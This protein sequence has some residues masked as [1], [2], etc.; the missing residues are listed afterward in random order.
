MMRHWKPTAVTL[1]CYNIINATY[2]TSVPTSREHPQTSLFFSL[3][4]S[5]IPIPSRLYVLQPEAVLTN[6]RHHIIEHHSPQ[7]CN[8]I[9]EN[10]KNYA[11]ISL[12][13][14]PTLGP[15][16]GTL[17]LISDHHNLVVATKVG[18]T[19]SS[20]TTNLIVPPMIAGSVSQ[21]NSVCYVDYFQL[22]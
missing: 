5:L 21:V 10:H 18:G 4:Q 17:L 16:H 7:L 8:H 12:N 15:H 14:S 6:W 13:T 9:M 19:K 20:N 22:H 2:S 1:Y 11:T 3:S